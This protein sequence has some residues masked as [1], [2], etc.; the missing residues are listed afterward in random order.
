V[1][2]DVDSP[3]QAQRPSFGVLER[4]FSQTSVTTGEVIFKEST[5]TQRAHEHSRHSLRQRLRVRNPHEERP[6]EDDPKDRAP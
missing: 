2:D 5:G 1:A 6:C 4:P 3:S